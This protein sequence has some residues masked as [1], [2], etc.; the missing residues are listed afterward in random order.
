MSEAV[1][2]QEQTALQEKMDQE[3]SIIS[4][5]KAMMQQPEVVVGEFDG[6]DEFPVQH[7]FANGV[8]CRQTFLP[9]GSLVIGKKHKYDTNNILAA[10]KIA[11]VNPGVPDEIREAPSV[12]RSPA[13]TKR[14]VVTLEDAVWITTH[15]IDPSWGIEDLDKIEEFVT[16]KEDLPEVEKLT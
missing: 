16:I 7:H 10:G 3:R 4:L 14:A 8:Y 15:P 13:G 1:M 11:T 9:A 6:N 2:N 12:W 5:A